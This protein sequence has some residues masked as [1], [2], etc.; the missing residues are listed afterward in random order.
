MIIRS[1]STLVTLRANFKRP[2]ICSVQLVLTYHGVMRGA[3]LTTNHLVQGRSE[4][5][6]TVTPTIGM[7]P[8]FIFEFLASDR[9]K[10]NMVCILNHGLFSSIKD[11]SYSGS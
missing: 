2:Q 7:V 3:N 9:F 1:S 11:L 4:E 10:L 8:F 6:V 5:D